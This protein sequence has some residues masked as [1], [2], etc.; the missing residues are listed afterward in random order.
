MSSLCFRV[1]Q[2][3]DSEA[4]VLKESVSLESPRSLQP[5]SHQLE[6]HVG[7]KKQW[8][9]K[10]EL[11][12]HLG[13]QIPPGGCRVDGGCGYWATEISELVNCLSES[14]VNP[15]QTQPRR[16]TYTNMSHAPLPQWPLAMI[17]MESCSMQC[18]QSCHVCLMQ[19]LCLYDS[20]IAEN[21]VTAT[22]GRVVYDV[23]LN[24]LIA[25]MNLL[26]HYMCGV[27]RCEW[28]GKILFWDTCKDSFM[29]YVINFSI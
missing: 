24:N 25:G 28:Y 14:D 21:S 22:T 6:R 11:V 27:N 9:L 19:V 2:A 29:I 3:L 13:I 18:C 20:A 8:L 23:E 10:N 1:K 15:N 17:V 26:Q 12:V 7:R 5:C 4:S 16:N